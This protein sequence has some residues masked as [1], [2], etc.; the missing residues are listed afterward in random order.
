MYQ[1]GFQ[2]STLLLITVLSL[3][4]IPNAIGAG[5]LLMPQP[6]E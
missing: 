3:I 2:S 1:S 4:A 6:L 5:D